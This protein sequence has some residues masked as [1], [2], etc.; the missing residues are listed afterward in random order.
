MAVILDI[1]DLSEADIQI[2]F[3]MTDMK[4]NTML[5]EAFCSGIYTGIISI[6]MWTVFSAKHTIRGLASH[7]MI[8]TIL[9]LYVLNTV[10]T[11]F[12]WAF[13]QWAFINNGG[14]FWTVFSAFA[15]FSSPLKRTLLVQGVSG[16]LSTLAADGSMDE[17]FRFG[18]AGLSGVNIGWLSSYPS[19]VFSQE[20]VLQIYHQLNDV[21]NDVQDTSVFGIVHSWIT[22]YISLILTTTILC[23]LLIIYRIITVSHAGMGIRTFRG[24]IE[25]IVE[26]AFIYSI[27]LLVYIVLITC[28]SYEEP[29]IDIL[30]CFARGIAPTLI[31]GRVAAGHTRPDESWEGSISSSLHFGCSSEDQSHGTIDSDVEGGTIS[32]EEGQSSVIHA[33]SHE[34]GQEVGGQEDETGQVV[35]I[36]IV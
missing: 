31:V 36:E 8:F 35:Y 20:Q 29:Y 26:S 5:F 1:P 32:T 25:I 28:N 15:T 13:N 11:S 22:A 7:A 17:P 19:Y 23:T 18:D 16:V 6:T 24:I 33:D 34:E 3:K 12:C 30:A 10:A 27:A 2:I 14:N 4:F 9:C 21:V